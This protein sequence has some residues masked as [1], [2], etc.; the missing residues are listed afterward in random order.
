MYSI[1][2][3]ISQVKLKKKEYPRS[4]VLRQS[5]ADYIFSTI[6]K[7]L[8][9]YFQI[10][11]KYEIHLTYTYIRNLQMTWGESS[12]STL[13]GHL[14]CFLQQIFHEKLKCS[15]DYYWNGGSNFANIFICLHNFLD[16]SLEKRQ[17]VVIILILTMTSIHFLCSKHF[18]RSF[19]LQYYVLTSIFMAKV[20]NNRCV[21]VF[22][23]L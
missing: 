4:C 20:N 3:K 10:V 2:P 17:Y 5:Y 8:Q 1:P 19:S 7:D 11:H 14:I 22:F 13:E 9:R 15:R 21:Q 18:F 12:S 16:S 6:P 23:L